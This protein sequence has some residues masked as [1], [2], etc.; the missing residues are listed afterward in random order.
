MVMASF[1]KPWVLFSTC[2]AFLVIV[3]LAVAPQFLDIT[4]A[5]FRVSHISHA[6]KTQALKQN[7]W[8]DLTPGEADDVVKFLL[9]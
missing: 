4:V 3:Y 6:V 8:A 7:I 2:V 1:S 9:F 5:P